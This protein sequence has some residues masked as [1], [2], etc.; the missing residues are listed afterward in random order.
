MIVSHW[1]QKLEVKLSAECRWSSRA[2]ALGSKKAATL[3]GYAFLLC[4]AL[5]ATDLRLSHKHPK[6]IYFVSISVTEH[7]QQLV[8]R[9]EKAVD[10]SLKE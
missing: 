5:E 7:V 3:L 6:I 2:P 9:L 10:V 8:L 4:L 1:R